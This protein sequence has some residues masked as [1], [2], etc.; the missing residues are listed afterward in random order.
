MIPLGIMLSRTSKFAVVD[1]A[2]T[3]GVDYFRPDAIFLQAEHQP[4]RNDIEQGRR[5]GLKIALTTRNSSGDLDPTKPLRGRA[6]YAY[7]DALRAT[8]EH[9][10][11]DI[12]VVE[13]EHDTVR[14]YDGTP[15]QYLEQLTITVEVG[16]DAGVAVADGGITSRL[17][18]LLV[19]EDLWSEDQQRALDFSR[20]ALKSL[21]GRE[22]PPADQD[23]LQRYL[24][25]KHNELE[26]GQK[27]I[28]GAADA[29]VDFT[30]FHWYVQDSQALA[31]A[32]AYLAKFGR[33]VMCNEMGQRAADRV[34]LGALLLAAVDAGIEPCIWY[35]LDHGGAVALQNPDGSLRDTG[36][37]FQ[38][39]CSLEHARGPAVA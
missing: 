24:H 21:P 33:P 6:K 28:Q 16:H 31:A 1:L 27:L 26:L 8:I 9:Y 20:V 18:A 5:E 30:N 35:S 37:V 19:T 14:Y 22:K 3:L 10:S 7:A 32:V 15:E 17:T 29:G 25:R 11:P 39:I 38:S 23:A 36:L 12:V 34:A 13:C 4:E 2:H